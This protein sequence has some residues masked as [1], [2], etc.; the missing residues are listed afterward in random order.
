MITAEI[1]S[2]GEKEHVVLSKAVSL[3]DTKSLAS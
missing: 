2:I 1:A 3:F